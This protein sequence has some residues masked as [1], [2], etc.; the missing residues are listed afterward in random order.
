VID[1]DDHGIRRARKETTQADL[2]SNHSH[3]FFSWGIN[4]TAS[5]AKGGSSAIT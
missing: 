2:F 3:G 4:R 5:A 1:S